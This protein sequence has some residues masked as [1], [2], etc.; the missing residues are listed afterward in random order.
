MND[1]DRLKHFIR[2]KIKN[3]KYYLFRRRQVIRVAYTE[4]L[5][6]ILIR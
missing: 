5:K 1:P 4:P 3:I 2:V 6:I